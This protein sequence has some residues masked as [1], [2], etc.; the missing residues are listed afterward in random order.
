MIARGSESQ[1]PYNQ[2]CDSRRAELTVPASFGA[3]GMIRVEGLSFTY[4]TA[5]SPTLRE[6]DFEV[7]AG[8]VFGFLGPSGAGK[9]TTQNILIGLL[10]GWQGEV[11]VLGRSV[12]RWGAD[13]YRS[14][15][16]SFEFPNHYLKLSAREN[17]EFFRALYDGN[18][19]RVED[20][21]ALVGLENE[22]DKLV[23]EFSLGMKNRLNF[24][25][26][27]LHRPQLCFH[28]E[29]TMG[30][31]PVNALR[32][33]ELIHARKQQGITSVV[34]THDMQTAAT[35]CDRVAFLVD[36]QITTIDAPQALCQRFGS[37]E[38]A[39]HWERV[40]GHE[41]G[42][43]RFPLERLADNES[44]LAALRQPGLQSIHTQ[45]AT[46]EDVFVKVTG[47]SLE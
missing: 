26:S 22:I 35:I 6:L 11:E 10:R 42:S 33:R 39:V 2:R 27:V 5:T 30:L 34:T 15:G 9:S 45:E 41:S 7:N 43:A 16:V 17:L 18:T 13:L 44:F 1:Q 36:G 23:G 24:A 47:R 14:I 28:D 8:E 4:P 20:V 12:E 25:R 3:N 32:I 31:D 19:E 38:V 37:R 21:L 46:L 29:P 40:A